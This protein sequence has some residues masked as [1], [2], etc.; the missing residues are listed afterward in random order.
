MN[1]AEQRARDLVD[2]ALAEFSADQPLVW[3]DDAAEA[4]FKRSCRA[5]LA[6]GAYLV[7]HGEDDLDDA[8]STW[9][10][11]T[12]TTIVGWVAESE[13]GRLAGSYGFGK[14]ANAWIALGWPD[15]KDSEDEGSED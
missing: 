4:S 2:Q 11:P 9:A 6:C 15:S 7:E 10:K 13:V 12:L 3:P 8:W 14:L 1:G 5:F